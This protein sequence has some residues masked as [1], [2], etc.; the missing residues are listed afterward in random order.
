MTDLKTIS[1]G[2]ICTAV[3]FKIKTP[4]LYEY[5][6]IWQSRKSFSIIT[7]VPNTATTIVDLCANFSLSM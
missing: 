4:T 5:I 7:T 3:R 2:G 1:G 6:T